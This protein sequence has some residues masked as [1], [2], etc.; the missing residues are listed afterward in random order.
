VRVGGERGHAV[1][2]DDEAVARGAHRAEQPRHL[3]QGQ[4]AGAVE[5]KFHMT[6]KV[7]SPSLYAGAGRILSWIKA[8]PVRWKQN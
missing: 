7:I 2:A 5:I 3:V 6:S 1:A 4:L 8:A